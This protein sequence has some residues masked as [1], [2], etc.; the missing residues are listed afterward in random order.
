MLPVKLTRSA[1][2]LVKHLFF[3]LNIYAKLVEETGKKALS[4][5]EIQYY[6]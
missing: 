2:T 5:L 1:K 4:S 6:Q 3:F